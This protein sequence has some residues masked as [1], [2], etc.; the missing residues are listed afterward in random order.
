MLLSHLAEKKQ[1]H[2][3]I[4]LFEKKYR[5]QFKEFE[6]RVNAS[7]IENFQEW[8]DLIEWQAYNDNF[9]HIS[10]KIDDI[11]SGNFKVA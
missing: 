5:L 10:Q 3:K 6:K 4:Q 1:L 11:R 2:E 8:D 7:E 9:I